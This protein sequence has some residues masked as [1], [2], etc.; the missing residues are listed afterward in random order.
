M[1][2]LVSCA[3]TNEPPGGP[4]ANA[5]QD[6]QSDAGG[7]PSPFSNPPAAHEPPPPECS[8]EDVLKCDVNEEGTRECH[9]ASPTWEQ[10]G[11]TVGMGNFCDYVEERD[12]DRVDPC[13]SRVALDQDEILAVYVDAVDGIECL[14]TLDDSCPDTTVEAN[15]EGNVQEGTHACA[16]CNDVNG[17]I[18]VVAPDASYGLIQL[19]GAACREGA[20]N[21]DL[22]IRILARAFCNIP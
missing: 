5:D 15:S 8:V 19:C 14:E 3:S 6:P 18:Y 1:I 20:G 11:L 13:V 21:D 4:M 10:C 22:R 17:W 12:T 2:L 9:C 7:A 16:V